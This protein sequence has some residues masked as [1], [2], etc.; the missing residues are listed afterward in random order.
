M[1]YYKLKQIKKERELWVFGV[2]MYYSL[3]RRQRN[4]ILPLSLALIT[5]LSI[6]GPWSSFAVSIKSQN[7][8]F[9]EILVQNNMIKE[10]KFI[11]KKDSINKDD[12]KEINAIIT[13]FRNNHN[14]E[15]LKYLPSDFSTEN[16]EEYFGFSYQPSRYIN[17][18]Y[19]SQDMSIDNYPLEISDYD[20]YFE[21]PNYYPETDNK[22]IEMG[23]E[24]NLIYNRE[25]FTLEIKYNNKT[26]YQKSL[27]ENILDVYEKNKDIQETK[28][29]LEDCTF[30]DEN[31]DIRIKILVKKFS[32]RI[33]NKNENNVIIDSANLIIF[34]SL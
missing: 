33:D 26:L 7:E 27:R 5:L 9:K 16:M 32:V 19:F 28:I 2:M 17:Y 13:Y 14:L 23:K 30:T 4:I 11:K 34:L 3:V 15:E 6:V 29:G 12:Q 25:S 31:E 10:E 24:I 20:Y 18:K 1:V 8:R 21:I 22:L